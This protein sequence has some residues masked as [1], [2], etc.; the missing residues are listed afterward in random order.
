MSGRKR[1]PFVEIAVAAS[2]VC[3][4]ATMADLVVVMSSQWPSVAEDRR[5][6][7]DLT[8]SLETEMRRTCRILDTEGISANL[9]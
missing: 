5:V 7:A 6:S 8:V 9:V 1:P 2:G 4:P 3:P